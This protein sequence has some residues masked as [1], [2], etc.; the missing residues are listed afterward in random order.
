[1]NNNII[2]VLDAGGTG[3]KFSVVKDYKEIIE[4]FTIP[5]AAPT[6]EEVLH[7]MNA[8]HV[9][10]PSPK[11]SVFASLVQPTTLTASLEIFPTY[12]LFGVVWH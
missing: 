2:F 8:R 7:S 10:R 6:L 4:P 3:F 11:P 1:M 5:S 9:A 12:P